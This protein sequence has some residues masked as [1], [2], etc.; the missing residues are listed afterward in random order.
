MPSQLFVSPYISKVF[1][2]YFEDSGLRNGHVT[3]ARPKRTN[4][5]WPQDCNYI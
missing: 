5:L 3:Q 4:E 2:Y 1:F